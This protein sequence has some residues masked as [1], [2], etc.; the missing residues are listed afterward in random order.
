MALS[1]KEVEEL[2]PIIDRTVVKFLGFSEP[3]LATAAVSCLEKGYD[4]NKTV[5]KL[6]DILEDTQAAKFTDKLY[7]ALENFQLALQKDKAK[8]RKTNAFE[9]NDPKKAKKAVGDDVDESAF[10]PDPGKPSPGQLTADKIKDMMAAAQKMIQERKAQLNA[11]P[12]LGALQAMPVMPTMPAPLPT[13]VMPTLLPDDKASRAAELQARI[14]SKLAMV[15][16]GG[17]TGAVQSGATPVILDAEG[18]TIDVK[19]GQAIQL[20]HHMPTLKAN[21]RAKKREQFKAVHE[22]PPEE[23]S[24]SKFFDPRIS[25]KGAVR[26][27]RHFKFHDKG[28]FEQLAQRMRTKA[29]LEKLQ[30]EIAQAAKK[31]G[32][33]SAAKLATIQPKK[34]IKTDEIPAVEW[35]DAVIMQTETYEELYTNGKD[36]FEG[37][38]NL[39]EHPIQMKPPDDSEE[40][41]QLA[42]MLTKDE[43]KKLRRQNRTEGQKELQEKIRLGLIPPPE[44]KVRMANLMRVLGTEAVQDPTKVEAHV[45][46][47]MAKRQ[48]AHEEANANRKLTKEQ[49]RQKKIDKIKED[50]THGVHV[51]VYRVLNLSN[52][53]K[54]FKVEMNAN[55]LFMTGIVVLHKDCNVLVVEGGPKQQK[56]FRK[57]VMSRIKWS[58]DSVSAKDSVAGSEDKQ[59]RV[60]SCQLVWEGMV[61]NHS[62]GEIKFK[63]CPTEVFAREQFKK[64]GVE[65]YWDLAYSSSV[66]EAT[67]EDVR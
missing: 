42:V 66:L 37:V 14:Q 24:E 64:F 3:T 54:K 31:T 61:R 52:P 17:D 22:K 26:G 32:I 65:H 40:P 28:K 30:N 1:R 39:V 59:H 43:R 57:L 63:A 48:R 34:D 56:K 33:A 46:A 67:G 44:P 47:Q 18:R 13:S 41:V 10:I 6:A 5:G 20:P 12:P 15:G 60:N 16:L 19:T 38:T 58:E 27:K 51:S 23:I 55:Q 25:N 8:K 9:E 50:T 53:A 11:M 29:Q 36:K 62:F 49:R 7:V 45:R 21:I 2:K 35:W 4:K